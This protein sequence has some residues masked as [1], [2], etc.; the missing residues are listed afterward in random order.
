MDVELTGLI[1]SKLAPTVGLKYSRQR[2]VG[3]KAAFAS[4]PAPTMGSEYE[5]EKQVGY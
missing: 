2:L 1:A 4:K 5:R 3:C